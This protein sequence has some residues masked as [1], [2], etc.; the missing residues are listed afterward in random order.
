MNIKPFIKL[1]GKQE[2]SIIV[3]VNDII[4]ID[5]TDTGQAKIFFVHS[6][7]S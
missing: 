4:A 6:R 3:S 1:K 7:T 2:T 5:S